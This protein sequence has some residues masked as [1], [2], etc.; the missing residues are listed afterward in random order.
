MVNSLQRYT[1]IFWT[2]EINSSFPWSQVMR[3]WEKSLQWGKKSRD[4][5]S[6]IESVQTTLNS[7]VI[8]SI[9]D[10]VKLSFAK[11][12]KPMALPVLPPPLT[13]SQDKSLTIS[14]WWIRRV[15]RISS[16]ESIPHQ[17]LEWYRRNSS[18]TSFLRRPRSWKNCPKG[19]SLLSNNSGLLLARFLGIDDWSWSYWS[20]TLPTP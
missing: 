3:Q 13:I 11:T 7:V 8:V 5:K 17:E 15:L 6:V 18:W 12:S 2:F 9:V 1:L 20:C 14:E 10:V 16:G 4:L 19:T